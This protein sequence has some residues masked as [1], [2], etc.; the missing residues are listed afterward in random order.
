MDTSNL[1]RTEL[2][3]V[4]EAVAREKSIERDEVLDVL[5]DAE[6]RPVALG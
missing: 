2:L 5:D 6:L 1:Y 3:Q 4:A